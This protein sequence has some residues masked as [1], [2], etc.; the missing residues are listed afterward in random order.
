MLLPA[1]SQARERARQAKCINNLKQIGTAMYM[2]LN[3]Y[4]EYF[5][6]A[7]GMSS[8]PVHRALAPYLGYPNAQY[9]YGGPRGIFRC[10]SHRPTYAGPSYCMNLYLKRNYW[11]H[12]TTVD[13]YQP[14]KLS[15][16]RHQHRIIMIA[17][18]KYN[19]D[20]RLPYNR[21]LDQVYTSGNPADY[22]SVIWRGANYSWGTASPRHNGI[23]NVVMVDG[24]CESLKPED[25][26]KDATDNPPGHATTGYYHFY[27]GWF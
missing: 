25:L 26:F 3:D 19:G 2:Y 5:P 7:P 23:L 20:P 16:V 15:K 12:P 13:R 27:S 9:Q 11:L 6:Y 8:N 14:V 17:D 24:H 1:L 21:L 4:E 18:G 22:E 10:P